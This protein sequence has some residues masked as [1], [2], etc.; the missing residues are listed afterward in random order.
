MKKVSE[1]AIQVG[2]QEES[3][4]GRG[5]VQWKEREREACLTHLKNNKNSDVAG[6]GVR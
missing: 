2:I 1:Q 5:A 4:R 6:S 3:I